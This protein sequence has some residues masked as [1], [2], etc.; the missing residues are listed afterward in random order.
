MHVYP[1]EKLVHLRKNTPDGITAIY[2]NTT[3]RTLAISLVGIF[4]PVYIFMQTQRVFGEG[5]AIGLYGVIVYYLIY[6]LVVLFLVIPVSSII[7]KIGF[8]WSL[9]FSALLLAI[10]LFLFSLTTTYFWVLIVAAIVHGTQ[11]AFYWLSYRSLFVKD[12]VLGRLGEE[13]SINAILSRVVA[14]GGPALGGIIIAT[15]GFSYLFWIALVIVIFSGLP[16]FFMHYHKRNKPATV[17]SV[18]NWLKVEKHRNEEISFIGR[19]IEGF[20]AAIFW[21]LFIFLIVGSYE[22]QGLVVS[23]GLVAGAI[24]ILF[25]GRIFD[26][27]Y[28]FKVYRFGVIWVSIIYLVRIFVNSLGKLVMVQVA[29]DMASPFY[30]VTF[31]SL[32]YE[33][34]REE[35]DQ[36]LTF[37]VSRMI[38][39]SIALFI[40]LGFAALI[41]TYEWRFSGLWILA[42][43][44]TLFTLTMWEGKHEKNK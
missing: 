7:S 38:M 30:W 33:R 31:D 17:S 32:V 34:A 27:K 26:K 42:S 3:L 36:V 22:K 20:V 10:M 5:I 18:I 29:Y 12:G 2:L 40:V 39:V 6:R 44:A 11:A 28:S 24:V 15:W 1:L 25:A 19:N 43:I 4:I 21:P 23:L 9:L 37:M 8:R 41:A 35:N 14:I 16:F 13:V